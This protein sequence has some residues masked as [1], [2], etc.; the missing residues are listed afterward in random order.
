MFYQQ[1]HINFKSITAFWSLDGSHV[2][3]FCVTTAQHIKLN[4]RLLQF[5]QYS[6]NILGL[7]VGL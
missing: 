2:F 1:M 7:L 5:M 4:K 6:L 3:P